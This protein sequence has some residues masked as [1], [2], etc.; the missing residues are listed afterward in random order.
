LSWPDIYL[1]VIAAARQTQYGIR[2]RATAQLN[3]VVFA[4]LVEVLWVRHM[5]G[6]LPL[7]INTP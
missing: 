4:E 3:E 2:F 1:L 6:W 5:C 7:C